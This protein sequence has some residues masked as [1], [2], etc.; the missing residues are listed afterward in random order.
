MNLLRFLPLEVED[1]PVT[2]PPQDHYTLMTISHI[3]ISNLISFPVVTIVSYLTGHQ[4]NS[5]A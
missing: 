2:A 5:R 4:R 3:P 1:V